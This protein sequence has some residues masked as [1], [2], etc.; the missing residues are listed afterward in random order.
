MRDIH[1]AVDPTR[2]RGDRL[3]LEVIGGEQGRHGDRLVHAGKHAVEE[4][5]VERH[6]GGVFRDLADAAH[7]GDGLDRVLAARGFRGQHH[8]VGPSSTALATSDTSARVGTG[9]EIIDSIICVAVMVSLFCSRAW[10]SFAFAAPEPRRRRLPRR[11]H[12]ARP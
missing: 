11:D 10:R 1:S 3:Y 8:R 5:A 12:R 2:E 4:I 6:L 9:L 7:R